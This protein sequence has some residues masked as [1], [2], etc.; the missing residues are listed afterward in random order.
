VIATKGARRLFERL[1]RVAGVAGGVVMI[2]SLVAYHAEHPANPEFAAVGYALW[3]G[4]V[5]LTTVGYGDI[6]PK[7]TTGR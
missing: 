6:V 4:I 1:G 2:G 5:T 7:T 3:W